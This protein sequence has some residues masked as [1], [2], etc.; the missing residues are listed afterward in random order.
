MKSAIDRE[1]EP[2]PDE[3]EKRITTQPPALVEQE[4]AERREELDAIGPDTD[5]EDIVYDVG[6]DLL[7]REQEV[8][9]INL[10]DVILSA[11]E[12]NLFIQASS[13]QPSI[14]AQEVTFAEAAFDALLF[15]NADFEKLDQPEVQPVLAGTGAIGTGFNNSERYRFETGLRK[16]TTLGTTFEISTDLTRSQNHTSGITL[17]PD[18]AYLSTVRLGLTQPLMRGFGKDVNTASIRLSENA[19]QEDIEQLR[20]DLL[21]IVADTEEAYWNLVFAWHDIAIQQWLVMVGEDVRDILD[22]RRD[23]DTKPAQYADAV[24]TV[25]QRKGDVIAA[26]RRLRRASDLLKTLINDPKNTIGSEVLL[27]PSDSLIETP[28]EY[29]LRDSIVTAIGNRPE[30]KQSALAISDAQIRQNVADNLR[31]PQLNLL[32]QVAYLGLDNDAGNSYEDLNNGDF[33]DYVLGLSFEYPLG[34]RAAESDY[35]RARL[36]R[37]QALVNYWNTVQFVVL[38]VKSTLRDVITTYELIQARRS[39]RV[40][41]AENLR[42]LL[43][44]EETLASL[45][46]E[47]LNLKFQRQEGLAIARAQE[48]QAM[49]N[50]DSSVA[51]LYRAMGIGL[52]MKQIVFEIPDPMADPDDLRP[53]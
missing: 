38:D 11:V 10:H 40:A 28:L 37:T 20:L 36:Q 53:R 46:P 43:V 47:F 29:S 2:L 30:I 6:H 44:E 45:T 25:E 5:R 52:K 35:Q 34:N 42:T 39:F 24:A 7:G 49:V 16:R 15:A 41:Q 23:F 13:L 3:S 9:E 32:A 19:Q 8:D 21:E 4:L 33:I 26:R 12:R 48:L 17:S 31:L 51:N 14:S 18:P 27:K 22:R 1:L 50:F